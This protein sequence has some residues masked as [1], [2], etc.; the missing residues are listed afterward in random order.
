MNTLTLE[1]I[2]N[3]PIQYQNIELACHVKKPLE[4]FLYK[5]KLNKGAIPLEYFQN[6]KISGRNN[7]FI[8]DRSHLAYK[9]TDLLNNFKY[10]KFKGSSI[11]SIYRDVLITNVSGI[12][13]DGEE[14]PLFYKHKLELDTREVDIVVS[15]NSEDDLSF[16]YKV[17]IEDKCIYT[18]AFN[19]FDEKTGR[20]K[21]IFIEEVNG[22]GETR[23]KLLNIEPAFG[24][25][26]WE[27]LDLQTG[28][29]L[30]PKGKY[31]KE[32]TSSGYK[33][34]LKG[35]DTYYWTPENS[36]LIRIKEILGEGSRE[37]WFPII[38]NGFA[39]RNV[40]GSGYRY[41]VSEYNQQVFYPS[42]PYWMSNQ[43]EMTFINSRLLS[44][45][46]KNIE[47]EARM[48]AEIYVYDEDGSLVEIYTTNAEKQNTF[49][50]GV[51]YITDVIESY[52][53]KSGIFYLSK[54]LNSDYTYKANVFYKK[55]EYEFKKLNM[56]PVLSKSNRHYKFVIYCIPNSS[57]WEE[58]VHYLKV[59]SED[60]IIECSQGKGLTYNSIQE[61]VDEQL[62]VDS[63]IGKNYSYG[64]D[65]FV[66]KYSFL[67]RANKNQYMIL[68]EMYLSNS[69]F[70]SDSF[71]F[72]L[73]RE[74]NE[75]KD[76][77]K[78][79]RQ[80]KNLLQSKYGYGEQGQ[81]YA[82]NKIIV[83]EI[84]IDFLEDYGGDLVES[85]IK[86]YLD[87][88]SQSSLN[89]IIRYTYPTV[90]CEY[91]GNEEE[92]VFDFKWPG[93]ETKINIYKRINGELKFQESVQFEEGT[94]Y[95]WKD[96]NVVE[97]QINRYVFSTSR[98]GKEYPYSDEYTGVINAK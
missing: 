96:S 20:Y 42:K 61:I 25:A 74:M 86:K 34:Y 50:Q 75:F 29:I 87:Y 48:P 82:E 11:S 44:S 27:D 46:L 43:K 67:N 59:N 14:V 45:N 57:V 51:K 30:N 84:P 1:L 17:S 6:D 64:E 70:I 4:K 66:K 36:N 73:E 2:S 10:K 77:K 38:S 88:F 72:E 60:K 52:D 3:G 41:Y 22:Q 80:N 93:P 40:N 19:I 21:I 92:I 98:N 83:V 68:G 49:L 97:N 24:E 35:D 9:D 53:S 95:A 31:T 5:K 37:S 71:H 91:R 8:F 54:S 18:N 23:K 39:Y 94:I 58:S 69:Q 16:I 85:D 81:N 62:N 32:K 89:K 78:C 47:V 33:F 7:V 13:N 28:K 15:T 63:I 76:P 79:Y 26:T 90:E 65:S 12:G 55:N 56:N